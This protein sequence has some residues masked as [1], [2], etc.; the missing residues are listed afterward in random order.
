MLINVDNP[1]LNN[2]YIKIIRVILLFLAFATLINPKFS[3]SQS[4]SAPAGIGKIA[5]IIGKIDIIRSGKNMP[6][7][8]D[9]ILYETDEIQTYDKTA[10]KLLF[11][12]GSNIMAF[13]NA[14]LKLI[15]Y[16]IKQKAEAVNDVKSAIDVVKGKVRFF[17][18]P[19]ESENETGK[20]DA[21]FKTSNS[22]MGI[23]GTSGFIDA[24]IP[25]NTQVIVTTG[26]VQVTSL[27]DPSK[28]VV[29]AANLYT[30]IVGNKAP[31]LPKAIPPAILN[32]LNSD[33]KALD[34]NFRLDDKRN[35]NT[36]PGKESG[37]TNTPGNKLGNDKSANVSPEINSGV[38]EQRKI[39]F[40]PDGS[41]SVVSTNSALNDLLVSQGNN[42]LRPRSY[43]D[44][45]PIKNSLQQI[46]DITSQL[47]R[48]ISQI[49]QTNTSYIINKNITINVNS[50]SSP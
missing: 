22:V 27:A 28:S 35:N 45:D 8:K 33:A 36:P 48:Q 41:N 34:P 50:P 7:E 44:Y 16:K 39:I 49:I 17:V 10:V 37:S 47:N 3:Y 46:S 5:N 9:S 25:G 14:H 13:Q 30:E 19:Q 43:A 12:D 11:N 4:Q 32:K 26:T 21:K 1:V 23:R 29:V 15:E 20:V 2:I 40:N 18:K 31:T 24:S 42:S 6:G 38:T